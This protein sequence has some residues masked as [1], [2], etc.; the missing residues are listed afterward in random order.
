MFVG[1][2]SCKCYGLLQFIFTECR[3]SLS[4]EVYCRAKHVISE[5]QRTSEAVTVL[6]KADYAT[7]GKLMTESHNSLR[8]TDR[9]T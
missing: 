2:T 6:K 7:F 3:S 1:V 9:G 5:I 8:Y 4:E